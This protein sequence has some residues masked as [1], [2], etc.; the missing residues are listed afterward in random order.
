MSNAFVLKRFQ[1]LSIDFV[2]KQFQRLSKA[3]F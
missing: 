3:F 2:L 1:R